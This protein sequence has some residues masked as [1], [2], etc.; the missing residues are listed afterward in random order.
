M[1]WQV[2]CQPDPVS[3]YPDAKHSFSDTRDQ[4]TLVQLLI[5]T[6]KQI[7]RRGEIALTPIKK[8]KLPPEDISRYDAEGELV[9]AGVI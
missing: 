1:R 5:Q 8:N 9:R 4:A 7:T 2:G 3:G 6:L